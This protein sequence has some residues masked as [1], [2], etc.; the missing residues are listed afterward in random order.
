MSTR[1]P[2]LWLVLS[3]L[4][5]TSHAETIVSVDPATR[6][7]SLKTGAGYKAYKLADKVDI[8]VG[9]AMAT[10]EK[11]EPGANV[12][13]G[14]LD[15]QTIN[16]IVITPPPLPGAFAAAGKPAE[17]LISLKLRIDGT[18]VIKVKNGMLW[19]EHKG[20]QLPADISIT[21]HAWKPKWDEDRSSAF[22]GF[23]GPLASFEGA[24]VVLTKSKGRGK[25]KISQQPS[26]QNNQTLE[27][28]FDDGDLGGSDLYEAKITW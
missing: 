23:T 15:S 7:I 12:V 4:I 18:D 10:L 22:I 3:I 1:F 13:F 25:A 6:L 20:W 28:V 26:D 24:K 21:G 17:H 16:R 27:V 9:N 2:A 8:R 19:I 11:L 5:L 14:L